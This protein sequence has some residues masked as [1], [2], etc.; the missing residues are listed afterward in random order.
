MFIDKSICDFDH[1]IEKEE[2]RNES[3]WKLKFLI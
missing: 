1:L 2:R 3:G